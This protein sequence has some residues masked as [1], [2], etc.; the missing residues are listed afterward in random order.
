MQGIGKSLMWQSGKVAKWQLL[1]SVCKI[2]TKYLVGNEFLCNFAARIV[3]I[4]K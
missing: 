3:Q 1:C 2:P 4:S